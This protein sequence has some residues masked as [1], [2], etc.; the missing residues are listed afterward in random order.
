MV[1]FWGSPTKN[2]P[3]ISFVWLKLNKPSVV[4]ING[5]AIAT[6]YTVSKTPLLFFKTTL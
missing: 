6:F 2:Q 1:A 3:Q 4:A 5:N